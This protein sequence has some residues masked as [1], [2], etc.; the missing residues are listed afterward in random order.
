MSKNDITANPKAMPL[1]TV[2]YKAI[3]KSKYNVTS[4]G[5]KANIMNHEND[6][7]LQA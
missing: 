2:N 1:P 6:G 7:R 5:I 3:T 4:A